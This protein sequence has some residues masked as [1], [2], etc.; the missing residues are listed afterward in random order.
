[1]EQITFH[2]VL[3]TG[4]PPN[5]LIGLGTYQGQWCPR[6]GEAVHVP[7]EWPVPNQ[8]KRCFMIYAIVHRLKQVHEISLLV[9]NLEGDE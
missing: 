6:I 5:G 3:R 4:P 2:V 1:M 8:D 7:D 9:R